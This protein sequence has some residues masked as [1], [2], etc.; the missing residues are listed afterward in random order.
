MLAALALAHDDGSIA[1]KFILGIG[2]GIAETAK[3]ENLSANGSV[4]TTSKFAPFNFVLPVSPAAG[5][6]LAVNPNLPKSK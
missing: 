1:R 2:I 4:P 6:V 3:A 5:T